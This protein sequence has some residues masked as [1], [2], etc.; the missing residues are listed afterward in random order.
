MKTFLSVFLLCIATMQVNAQS[1]FFKNPPLTISIYNHF[2]GVPF[3]DFFKK[4]I[5]IGVAVGMEF[6]YGQNTVNTWGQKLEIGWYHHKNLSTALW[7]KTDLV[8]LHTTSSGVFGEAQTG[9]GYIHDFNAQQTFKQGKDGKYKTIK[10]S[11][12]GGLL[13]GAGF[14]T[15]YVLDS[16]NGNTIAPFIRYEAMLQTPYSK[17]QSIFPHG[18]LHLGIRK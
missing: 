3:K 14:G 10:H 6:S 16:D 2:I 7:I 9:I 1:D 5:N 8:Y 17:F 12:K 15:G 11:G 13:L 18:L 4:P